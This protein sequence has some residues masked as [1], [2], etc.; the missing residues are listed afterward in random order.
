[1]TGGTIV[2][3]GPVGWNLGAGMTGGQA[4]VFDRDHERLISRLNP[5]LVDAVRPDM[6]AI[7]EV[8]WLVER[9]AELTGSARSATLLEHWAK[10]CSHVWH[11]L[12]KDQVRRYEEGQ[13]SRVASV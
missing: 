3:M 10:A 11:V 12:P 7:E 6:A 4:F 5:D 1:M 2:V 9:H 8:R 13:A